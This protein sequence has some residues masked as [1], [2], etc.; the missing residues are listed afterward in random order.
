VGKTKL[1]ESLFPPDEHLYIDLLNPVE[2]ENLSLHPAELSARVDALP[3]HIQWIIIDEIQRVPELLNVVHQKIE[4]TSVKFGLTGSS[5]RKLKR[6]GANLLAG[7][8]YTYNLFPLTSGE[9]GQAFELHN[10]LEWGTL[11]KVTSI[12]SL[13]ERKIYLQTYVH[14][15]IR[16]EIQAEQIVRRVDPF[17]KFLSIAAQSNGSIVS[18][19][20]IAR[21]VGTSD[22]TVRTYFEILEDTLIGFTLE[23]YH[24]SIRK[25]QR[26][27]PKFYF[28]DTGVQRALTRTLDVP[29][30][31][32][33][34]AF[35]R[36]F[37]HFIICEVVRRCS[38]A[39]N[40]FTFSYLRTKDDAEIDL[41]L[42]RPGMTTALIEIKSAR[43]VGESDV[44]SI[45]NF[46]PD[47]PNAEA[48]CLS[49]DPNKKTLRGV[50]CRHWEEG[51]Q[52][53]LGGT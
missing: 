52:E 2:Y 25:R 50:S 8:A 5:A 41:I 42:E 46:L 29:L 38:Y 47:F 44:A 33:T 36:A 9:L 37:E 16:E 3:P 53:I 17:R 15:Y 11:P 27:G 49:L 39:R 14:T 23:P 10:A 24:A 20:N 40:D 12:D 45:A 43:H 21:D 34:Y 31:E 18:F 4:R 48:F 51:L 28:F 35:G 26:G 1:I 30:K 19:S 32:Q 6:G 13:D 7:R 22:V